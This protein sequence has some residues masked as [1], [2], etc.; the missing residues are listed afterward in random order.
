M[1]FFSFNTII[2]VAAMVG[3]AIATPAP[4]PAGTAAGE[5]AT[6]ISSWNEAGLQRYRFYTNVADKNRFVH[7]FQNCGGI[8]NNWQAWEEN[9]HGV[10]DNS[11]VVGWLGAKVIS[12]GI[13][14]VTGQNC[15]QISEIG[16]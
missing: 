14:T 13:Q 9:G 1:Q 4:T 5:S 3:S 12:C 6:F 2:F 10:F 8:T 15:H 16:C 11:E 7:A